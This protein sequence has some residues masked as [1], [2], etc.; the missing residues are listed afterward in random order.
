MTQLQQAHSGIDLLAIGAHPDDIEL[1]AGGVV[2]SMTAA[3]K[4]VVIVDCTR[5][6]MGT[7]GSAEERDREAQRASEILGVSERLNLAM[8]D[9]NIEQSLENILS[10]V[11]VLRRYRPHILLIPP[12]VER[13]PDHESVHRLCRT[14][15]FKSGLT[16]VRTEWDNE[17]QRVF[18]PAHTFCYIQS[19]HHEADFFVDI[20]SAHE[21]KLSSIRAY[22]SQ[23]HVPQSPQ[24]SE[25]QTFISKPDFMEMIEARARYFGGQIGCRFAEGFLCVGSLGLA[26]L[27][28]FL[29]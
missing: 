10:V 2:A 5:G 9:G 19:Y 17:E 23:V 1:S 20:S 24:R 25:P 21:T 26:S 6:E 7:R 13:H 22:G 12:P 4:R 18:S 15:A 28:C 14:A 3:G 8:P 11:R 29:P 27:E 16:K